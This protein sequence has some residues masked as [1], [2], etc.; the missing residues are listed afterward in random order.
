MCNIAGYVGE[1]RAAPIL[2]E[3]LKR[4]EGFEGGYSTGIATLHEGKIYYAKLVG[5]VDRLTSLT[6]AASLPGNIGII[7]SRSGGRE[8]AEWAHPFI[9]KKNGEIV[10]AYIANGAQGFFRQ[11]KRKL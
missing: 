11:F 1:R 3:M 7:H 6:E 10:T 8:G 9:A 4:E 5:D 2:L